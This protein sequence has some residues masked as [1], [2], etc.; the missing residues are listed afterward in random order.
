MRLPIKH[1]DTINEAEHPLL[2]STLLPQEQHQHQHKL[3]LHGS[4]N[5]DSLIQRTCLESKKLWQ[6]AGPSIFSRLT[7]FSIT[8]VTQSFAG[9]LSDLDLTAITT[10][11]TVLISISLRSFL[12]FYFIYTITLPYFLMAMIIK[13]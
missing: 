11:C 1:M 5:S 3:R 12:L 13:M 4:S 9:H 6:I 2:Q 7:M 8:V 10:A